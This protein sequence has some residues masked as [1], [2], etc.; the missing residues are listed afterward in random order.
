MTVAIFRPH[1]PTGLRSRLPQQR[2]YPTRCPQRELHF[3]LTSVRK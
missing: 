3:P 2:P 1:I